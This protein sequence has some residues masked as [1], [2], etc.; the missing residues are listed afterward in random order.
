VRLCPLGMSATYWPTVPALDG[1][2][3]WS[4]WWNENWQGK[5][6]HSEKTCPSATLSTTNPTW[7]DLGSNPGRCG[8]KLATNRLSY[9]TASHYH[10][11]FCNEA[12][13]NHRTCQVLQDAD[14]YNIAPLRS[15]NSFRGLIN[16][17]VAVLPYIS[18]KPWACVMNAFTSML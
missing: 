5:P 15:D 13:P 18:D 2:W 9:G 14:Q 17:K 12:F 6:K 4:S 11:D 1:R 3:V 16:G 8:G 10:S 7:P